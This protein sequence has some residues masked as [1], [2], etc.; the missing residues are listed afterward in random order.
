ME[1]STSSRAPHPESEPRTA[2]RAAPRGSAKLRLRTHELSLHGLDTLGARDLLLLV[3]PRERPLQGLAGL[4]DWRLLGGLSRLLR[5]GLF[6]GRSSESLLTLGRPRLPA[7]RIFLYGL[8]LEGAE[9]ALPRALAMVGRAGAEEVAMAPFGEDVA[10][11]GERAEVAARAAYDAG[12]SR[13]ICLSHR[14]EAAA[15]AL[16]VVE[17]HHPWAVL[18][19]L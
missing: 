7:Q 10:A 2:D 12:I 17:A 19:A 8:G 11:F 6:E 16:V 4:V 3:G 14:V 13:L 18:E 5:R 1:S 15:K 9:E